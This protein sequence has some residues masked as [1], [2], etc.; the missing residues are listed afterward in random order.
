MTNTHPKPIAEMNLAELNELAAQLRARYEVLRAET[1]QS[2][3]ATMDQYGI[4]EKAL[5]ESF[6]R[7][8]RPRK[9]KV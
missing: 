6:I 3:R 5:A 7:R 8:R 9:A 4:T 1:V 2:I